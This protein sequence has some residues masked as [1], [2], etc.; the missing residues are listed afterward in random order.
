M[1][2]TLFDVRLCSCKDRCRVVQLYK[3][4]YKQLYIFTIVET[5]EEVG[6]TAPLPPSPFEQ[7]CVKVNNK[8]PSSL[9]KA[10]VETN[11][12]VINFRIFS[13]LNRAILNAFLRGA[14]RF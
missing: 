5:G 9:I 7:L 10:H 14:K 1:N 4:L 13:P 12:V 6:F 3:Q 2:F 8:L 11:L